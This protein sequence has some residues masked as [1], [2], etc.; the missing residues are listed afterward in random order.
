MGVHVCES[1][2]YNT[3]HISPTVSMMVMI[4]GGPTFPAGMSLLNRFNVKVSNPSGRES[5]RMVIEIHRR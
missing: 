1:L 4:A 5:S 3:F 2:G